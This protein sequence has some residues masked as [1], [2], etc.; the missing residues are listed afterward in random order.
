MGCQK[1]PMPHSKSMGETPMPLTGGTPVLLMGETPMLREG[2]T[3]SA[4]T[5]N[6][7]PLC[8]HAA[9][10]FLSAPGV[11]VHAETMPGLDGEF[12][13]CHGRGGR[14]IRVTGVLEV[15][16]ATAAGAHQALKNALR[17]VQSLADGMTVATYIGTDGSEYP[18]CMLQ[19]YAPADAVEVCGNP[20]GFY[21]A[22]VCVEA[23]IHQARA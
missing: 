13:Q 2:A 4:P 21:R 11:R 1:T 16:G 22:V 19:A 12:I 10:E 15:A 8:T 7:Q 20:A 3:M 23:T 17:G 14:D 6:N 5:F 9:R 18:D